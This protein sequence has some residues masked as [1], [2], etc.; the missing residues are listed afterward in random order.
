MD[1]LNRM[2]RNIRDNFPDI[3]PDEFAIRMK[4][5]KHLIAMKHDK[6]FE[7]KEPQSK[8]MDEVDRASCP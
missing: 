1:Y 7:V 5:A 4:L 8:L 3:T 6:K 2:E